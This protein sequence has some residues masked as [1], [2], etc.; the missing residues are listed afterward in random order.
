MHCNAI[1][2]AAFVGVC[3]MAL[4][5][6]GASAPPQQQRDYCYKDGSTGEQTV[7]G[8]APVI[9]TGTQG[10]N[11]AIA[12]S[13]RCFA[14]AN[15]QGFGK[16]LTG[17][18]QALKLSPNYANGYNNRG[19]VSYLMG[20]YEKAFQDFDKAIKLDPDVVGRYENWNNGRL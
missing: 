16:A 10:Q 4:A 1:R 11:L 17:C 20:D 2:L 12:Y 7:A 15:K 19:D 9:N 5:T 8:C 13:N 3:G 18:D 14:L 6:H